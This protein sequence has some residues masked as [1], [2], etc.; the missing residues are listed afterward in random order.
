[1][2]TV[3]E[4]RWMSAI[5]RLGC[6]VCRLQGYPGAPG[7]VH[8]MLSGGR[9]R[10]HLFTLCLCSPGHHR[11]GD[12]KVKVSRHPFKLRFEA[13]YGSEESLLSETRQF[14]AD[15][16]GRTRRSA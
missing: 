16:E 10:G 2:A 12:G 13:S 5:V 14:V 11:N 8:H 1:M 15:L 4:R 6:I 3:E 7:E 9:R